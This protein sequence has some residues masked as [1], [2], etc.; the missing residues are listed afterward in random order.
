MGRFKQ[1]LILLIICVMVLV[2]CGIKNRKVKA[3]PNKPITVLIG[4]KPGGGSDAVAQLTEHFIEKVLNVTFV[5]QYIPGATGAIAWTK[6]TKQTEADGYTISVTNTPMLMTNY[7]INPEISYNIFEFEPLA[8]IVTDPG[9]IV[10]SKDSKFK[11]IQDFLEYAKQNPGKTTVGNSGVGGDD[12]FTT[13]IVEKVTGL[14]F[15]SI[16][17]QGDAPSWQAAMAGKIDASFNNLGSSFSQI[18][19]KNLKTLVIFANERNPLLLDVP[20][21]K[22][23]GYDVVSGSSRGFSA[24]KGIPAEARE[25]MINGFKKISEDTEFQKTAVMSGYNLNFKFGDEYAQYLSTQEKI[26]KK[27]WEEVQDQYKK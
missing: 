4:F 19:A 23:L 7:L 24:P 10:V 18:K 5:N 25:F 13:L 9:I 1:Y 6:L 26:L 17:F 11:T 20:T 2:S 16:P 27:I 22:E 12:F 21:M 3:F 15:Q 8:N 14:K